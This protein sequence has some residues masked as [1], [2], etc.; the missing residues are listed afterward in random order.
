MRRL[1]Y[2]D[3]VGSDAL[4]GLEYVESASVDVYDDLDR[5][6]R[7]GNKFT[8]L[9]HAKVMQESMESA[10]AMRARAKWPT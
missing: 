8:A 9:D 10:A 5:V 3:G 4:T 7:R 1:A 6:L 2:R